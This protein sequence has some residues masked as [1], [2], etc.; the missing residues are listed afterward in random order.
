MAV[1]TGFPIGDLLD[2]DEDMLVT[3]VEA[4]NERWSRLEHLIADLIEVVDSGN[5]VREVVNSRQ[6]ARPRKRIEVPRPGIKRKRRRATVA[7]MVAMVGVEGV[8]HGD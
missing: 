6:G 7:E 3:L 4:H 8:T 5:V 1:E 2:L